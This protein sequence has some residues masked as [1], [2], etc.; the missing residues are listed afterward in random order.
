MS[1]DWAGVAAEIKAAIESV[2]FPVTFTRPG[3]GSNIWDD[4]GSASAAAFTVRG[5]DA[6]PQR[7][8]FPATTETTLSRTIVISAPG[9]APQ[10]G[11]KVTIDGAVHSVQKIRMV[12]PGGVDLLYR[13]ELAA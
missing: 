5:I 3:A 12:S 8:R 2:G 9:F 1:E 6:K 4:D 13:V 10:M 7:G 11:D